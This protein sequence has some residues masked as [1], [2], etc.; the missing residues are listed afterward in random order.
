M[1]T[2]VPT[3]K[4]TT[5]KHTDLVIASYEIGSSM[6]DREIRLRAPMGTETEKND[7]ISVA[8]EYVDAI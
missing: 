1:P 4:N 5:S 2:W 6:R 3:L 7:D 8:V